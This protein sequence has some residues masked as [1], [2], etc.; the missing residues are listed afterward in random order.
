M[1]H[2]LAPI[3]EEPEDREGEGEWIIVAVEPIINL[4][5]FK[6]FTQAA[7]K[8]ST[9]WYSGEGVGIIEGQDRTI[10]GAQNPTKSYVRVVERK[11][12][13]RFPHR[14]TKN[15]YVPSVSANRDI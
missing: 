1:R 14:M 5:S 6:Q 10:Q 8:R 4:V 7:E 11:L 13:P 2:V 15:Y 9:K 3:R 12:S